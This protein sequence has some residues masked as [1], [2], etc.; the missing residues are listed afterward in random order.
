LH[1][2]RRKHGNIFTESLP[3]N[4]RLFWLRYSGF[5]VSYHN[6]YLGLCRTKLL[7]LHFSLAFL[8][9]TNYLFTKCPQKRYYTYT[10]WSTVLLEKLVV[11]QLFSNS[12]FIETEV[13]LK[14][15]PKPVYSHT[16]YM[17]QYCPPSTTKSFEWPLSCWVSSYKH[18]NTFGG[19]INVLVCWR[20]WSSSSLRG[21]YF[22]FLV[23]QKNYYFPQW[24]SNY[25][26]D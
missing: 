9:V 1:G 18:T 19:R 23:S 3:G 20:R 15:N 26:N 11:T 5:Q 17:W 25:L 12:C 14:T 6:I 4:E 13:S 8:R 21:R 22:V 24:S 10:P 2:P 7:I 16:T